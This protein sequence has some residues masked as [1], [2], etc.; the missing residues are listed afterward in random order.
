MTLYC[1]NLIGSADYFVPLKMSGDG[2]IYKDAD[3]I[4]IRASMIDVVIQDIEE[5]MQRISSRI[6]YLNA[7]YNG[8][9][10]EMTFLTAKYKALKCT[11]K[12]LKDR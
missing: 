7:Q 11:L 5:S 9:E 10:T 8:D 4:F 3:S 12:S 2:I 1:D 6:E